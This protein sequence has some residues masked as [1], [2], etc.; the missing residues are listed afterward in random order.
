MTEKSDH[1]E[2]DDRLRF[3]RALGCVV[4]ALLSLGWV[5]FFVCSGWEFLGSPPRTI[6]VEDPGERL[7]KET[8]I[9]LPRSARPVFVENRRVGRG[10]GH[11]LLVYELDPDTVKAL[12]ASPGP[13]GRSWIE[14][15]IG[16]KF[17]DLGLTIK[18]R[19]E[20]M[21]QERVASDR[22]EAERLR[23]SPHTFFH[24]FGDRDGK[25]VVVDTETNR[26]YYY[27][28]NS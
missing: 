12:L 10:D 6:V 11:I 23:T 2:S 26:L 17:G 15:P 16:G 7:R 28:W 4:V 22:K 25:A 5:L 3:H 18:T 19:Y 21:G 27:E 1:A 20:E 13:W 9:A 14:G 24:G 8:G